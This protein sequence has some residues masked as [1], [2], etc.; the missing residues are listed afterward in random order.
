M[1]CTEHGI[2]TNGS[3]SQN[4]VVFTVSTD[5]MSFWLNVNV[6]IVQTHYAYFN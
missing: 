2:W 1:H 3:S 5:W 4:D 6:Y